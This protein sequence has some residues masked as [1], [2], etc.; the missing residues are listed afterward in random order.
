[1]LA[2]PFTW[3]A[4]LNLLVWFIHLQKSPHH[5][6]LSIIQNPHICPQ[7]KARQIKNLQ[8]Q[9][10]HQPKN[11]WLTFGN[12]L[13]QFHTILPSKLWIVTV[14]YWTRESGEGESA[15]SATPHRERRKPWLRRFN[16]IWSLGCK[17]KCFDFFLSHNPLS[18]LCL[19]VSC[20]IFC[21]CLVISSGS[22]P[23]DSPRN[24]SPSNPAHFSFASSRRSLLYISTYSVIT[25]VYSHLCCCCMLELGKG[26]EER[27][28]RWGGR[29]RQKSSQHDTKG[30]EE[31]EQVSIREKRRRGSVVVRGLTHPGER[32]ASRCTHTVT[33]WLMYDRAKPL[34]SQ[35]LCLFTLLWWGGKK[36][37][38]VCVCGQVAMNVCICSYERAHTF[39]FIF[40]SSVQI[41]QYV[42]TSVSIVLCTNVRDC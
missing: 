13:H 41:V 42:Y 14:L 9:S 38:C 30:R 39:A 40:G 31:R 25:H 27:L 21:L 3:A 7:N 5:I 19:S 24:F 22:S 10:I 2:G 36:V 23:L 34:H 28:R 12:N 29:D 20:L 6:F 1:M 32:G 8:Q 26:Q 18:Y 17:T 16:S 15:F 4:P 37:E 11:Q 33:G 35:R